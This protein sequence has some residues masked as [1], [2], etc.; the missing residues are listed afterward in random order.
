MAAKITHKT[1]AIRKLE[2]LG[3]TAGDVERVVRTQGKAVSFDLFGCIDVVAVRDE[4]TLGLQV[5]SPTNV[6]AHVDK[7]LAEGRLWDCLAAGWLIECWG[8][9]TK[10][11]RDGSFAV[12][13][14]F[15]MD[16]RGLVTP[17]DDS[18][19]I[20]KERQ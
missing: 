7:M 6:A 18:F 3:W 11:T 13:R 20:P 17:Y 14:R 10:A 19:V 9:R 2:E 8:V 12:V 16:K 5:T 1:R 4:V 15:E